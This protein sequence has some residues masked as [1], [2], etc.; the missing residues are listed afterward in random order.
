MRHR[1]DPLCASIPMVC[2]PWMSMKY[3]CSNGTLIPIYGV[4]ILL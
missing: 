4:V 3:V 2:V 1:V